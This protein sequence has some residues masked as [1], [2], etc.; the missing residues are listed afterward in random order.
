MP[1]AAEMITSGI[2]MDKT[3]QKESLQWI[4]DQ[5]LDSNCV[6]SFAC[7]DATVKPHSFE[8]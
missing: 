3:Q 4:R 6:A 7:H 8:F 2:S 5:S 1:A